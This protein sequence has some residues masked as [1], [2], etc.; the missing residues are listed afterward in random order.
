MSW[1]TAP[2]RVL[3]DQDGR[4]AVILPGDKAAIIL[5]GDKAAIILPSAKAHCSYLA[6]SRCSATS[7]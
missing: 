5:P 7:G 4:G 1:G 3:C 6:R 2:V